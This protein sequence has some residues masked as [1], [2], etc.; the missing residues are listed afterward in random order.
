MINRAYRIASRHVIPIACMCYFVPNVRYITKF[1][2]CLLRL[3]GRVVFMNSLALS[4]SIRINSTAF[5]ANAARPSM[6][7]RHVCVKVFS[8]LIRSVTSTDLVPSQLYLVENAASVVWSL[9]RKTSI[10]TTW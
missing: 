7:A 3:A 8:S 9:H 4:G 10:A 6:D 1:K 2:I 5:E